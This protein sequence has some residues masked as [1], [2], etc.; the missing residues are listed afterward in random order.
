MSKCSLDISRNVGMS[1]TDAHCRARGESTVR[2]CYFT[3][4]SNVLLT[5]VLYFS[6]TLLLVKLGPSFFY[7]LG[8]WHCH[9]FSCTSQKT[10]QP[11]QLFPASSLLTANPSWSPIS[12]LFYTF[13]T[14]VCHTI[15]T[16]GYCTWHALKNYSLFIWNS[17][18]I[19]HLTLLY[20]KP[21][22]PSPINL[23]QKK[24]N[25]LLDFK[26]CA[27]DWTVEW[28]VYFVNIWY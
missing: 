6:V 12:F 16:T 18:L 20:V 7:S 28:I 27:L 19:G 25:W 15:S 11:P 4:M 21:G 17:D 24:Q 2:L 13:L 8:N 22:N 10:G 5:Q 14:H 9:S 23:I 26:C 1:A 3:S